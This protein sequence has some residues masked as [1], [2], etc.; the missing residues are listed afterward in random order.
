MSLGFQD[1]QR[2]KVACM[3]WSCQRLGL[4]AHCALAYK[5]VWPLVIV[6]VFVEASKVVVAQVA[7]V[8][9]SVPGQ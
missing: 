2:I 7:V 3:V 6:V 5:R 1:P 9:Q 8:A 4:C